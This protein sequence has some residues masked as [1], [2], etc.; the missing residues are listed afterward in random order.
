MKS[1]PTAMEETMEEGRGR[2]AHRNTSWELSYVCGCEA[3]QRHQGTAHLP[4]PSHLGEG[5]IQKGRV[6]NTHKEHS[7]R[8][9]SIR[10]PRRRASSIISVAGS[11][12]EPSIQSASSIQLGRRP[13]TT[14]QRWGRRHTAHH[15]CRDRGLG[16]LHP[17]FPGRR[18]PSV[19]PPG[20]PRRRPSTPAPPPRGL[21]RG[22][23][24]SELSKNRRERC[25]GHTN[26]H[27]NPPSLIKPP[28]FI[29]SGLL[30]RRRGGL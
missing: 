17:V 3:A 29:G 4:Q 27:I 1:T 6:A 5:E 9:A 26:T 8:T 24:W 22:G 16:D 10:L 30:G 18:C 25:L 19:P 15:R 20:P 11:V 14:R 2:K 28:R 7:H 12:R 23:G 21:G 13:T